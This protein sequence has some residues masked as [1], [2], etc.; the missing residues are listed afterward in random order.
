MSSNPVGSRHCRSWRALVFSAL[1]LYV[2]AARGAV[3]DGAVLLTAA[4]RYRISQQTAAQVAELERAAADEARAQVSK[5]GEEWQSA[6]LEAIRGELDARF[7]RE[8]R[9]VFGDFLEDFA[10]AEQAND[11]AY[12]KALAPRLGWDEAPAD[13]AALRLR[14]LRELVAEDVAAAGRLLGEMQSWLAVRAREAGTPPLAAWLARDQP[15]VTPAT[16]TFGQ[17]LPPA[18]PARPANPLRDAEAPPGDFVADE[19]PAATALDSFSTARAGRRAQALEEAQAAMQQV[20]LERRTAEEEMAARKSAA[21]QAEAEAVRKQAERLAAADQEAIEQR[22][23]SWSGRL[24]SILCT[25]IGATSGAFLGGVG[26]RAGEEA[27]R[28]VFDHPAGGR[29]GGGHH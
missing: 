23:N 18:R 25:T 29:H 13:F 10:R 3:P 26:A 1:V 24:K 9:A 11:L 17:H 14:S 27:A 8:A 19:E 28:A 15:S 7:G 16:A 6:V 21:A 2:P 4:L 22:K 20:A 12:L 5:A